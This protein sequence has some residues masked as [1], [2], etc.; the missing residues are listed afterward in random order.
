MAEKTKFHKSKEER[1]ENL[2]KL[3]PN[4]NENLAKE[5]VV[6]NFTRDT[7]SSDDPLK[8]DPVERVGQES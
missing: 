8:K 2:S 3:P 6:D 5:P 7:A 1:Q 4:P